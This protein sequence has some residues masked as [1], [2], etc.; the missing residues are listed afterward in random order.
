MTPTQ[1]EEPSIYTSVMAHYA[2]AMADQL[3]RRSV[4]ETD[5]IITEW[6]PKHYFTIAVPYFRYDHEYEELRIGLESKT[7]FTWG[8][9]KIKRHAML[10]DSKKKTGNVIKF[11]RYPPLSTA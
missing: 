6:V 10:W 9:K 11:A 5:E 8:K 3:A 1:K 2:Q 7:L 4:F